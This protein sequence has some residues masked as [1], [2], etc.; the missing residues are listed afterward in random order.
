MHWRKKRLQSSRLYLILDRDVCSYDV[1][2]EI[3]QKS[4][5]AGIDLMQLRDKTGTAKEM[6]EFSK[7]VLK[8]TKGKA[9]YI[10]N[11]R[12]DLARIANADGV[13]LGQDDLSIKEART[14][15]QNDRLIGVSCQNIGHMNKVGRSADYIGFGSVFKTETKPE[16]HPMDLGLLKKAVKQSKVPLF[17]VGG[18]NLKNVETIISVGVKRVA[19]C[20]CVC[21][22]SDVK[23]V[24]KEFKTELVTRA[25]VT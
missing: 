5:D 3:A 6:L 21:Q 8:L 23:K 1:L 2:F 7:A 4:V 22:A 17:A 13:H 18:I 25:L 10:I 12:V 19:V 24:V 20:R 11:D 15:L 14:L 16:R 9:L